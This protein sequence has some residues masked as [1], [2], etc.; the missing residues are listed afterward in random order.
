MCGF[1]AEFCFDN[2]ITSDDAIFTELLSLSK[3]RGPDATEVSR[4]DTYQLGFNRLSILD[5]SSAGNQPKESP[6]KRYHMVFNGEVYNYEDLIKEHNLTNLSSTSDTE[7][8]CHLLD[9]LGI[10]ATIKVLNGMFAIAVVDK[11]EEL[12]ILARDFAGIKPHFFGVSPN[13]IVSASQFDQI[14][15]HPWHQ[16]NRSLRPEV[17]KEY[18]AFG[19]MQAP[20]TIYDSIFQLE[21]G[22][23]SIINRKG[24]ITNK[25]ICQFNRHTIQ[26]GSRS[27]ETLEQTLQ[28]TVRKQ[29]ASD[30]P[31][32]TF[33]S[34][35]IDSPLISAYAKKQ[36]HDIEAFTIKVNDETLNESEI[37]KLY[38]N[39]LNLKQHIHSVEGTDLIASINSHFQAFSEPFGD[40][41]SIPT[42]VI[43]RESKK[44][45]TVMLSGDGGDELFFGYPRMLDVLKKAKW[46]SLP[47]PVR[48][49][50]IRI[51]NK[52]GITNTW[53][54]FY[55]SLS[56]FIMYKHIQ[57][58][59]QELHVMFPNVSMT[60]E[61]QTL[62]NF[63]KG[64]KKSLLLQLRWNEFYAH[65]QRV[66][67]KVDRASMMN[68][69]EVRVPFLDREVIEKAW[70]SEQI[71]LKDKNDLKR[72]LK[73]L[74]AK[75]IPEELL[76]K[77]KMGFAVPIH[78][79]LHND[80][81]EDVLHY[82]LKLPFYGREI[83]DVAKMKTFIEDYYN[84][85]HHH[86][87]GIWHIYAWQK[88]A[89]THLGENLI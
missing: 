8:I 28:T 11:Q 10:E 65:M 56:E 20:N 24:T 40:F 3:H 12:F 37:A 15:K 77:K 55:E 76:N 43:S 66:L 51:T 18:F 44:R 22:T 69:L 53:A 14:F 42:Y 48:K 89:Y 59:K 52:L 81:K 64:S 27:N 38:A 82:T 58:P 33:L 9:Q 25:V 68:S 47:L 86:F 70:S 30:V 19:Y 36:K 83:I 29:L 50:L 5:I 75:E 71:I 67:I 72:K 35:G 39:H 7:V 16:N 26:E 49:I 62:Y 74:L 34:G 21:P 73:T 45:Y 32:A 13:G 79:W 84:N 61:A 17:M 85:K 2:F 87:W 80:L 4:T 88:W 46:F 41:S 54:P 23:I 1:L 31:I 63:K 60:K 6:S 57:I 78:N